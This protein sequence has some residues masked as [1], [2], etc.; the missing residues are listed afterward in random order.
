MS[1]EL[2]PS[3]GSGLTA[4]WE[5]VELTATGLTFSRDV[6]F[7]EWSAI[8]ERLQ[9]MGKAIQF[10]IGDW[11]RYGEHKFGEKYT[12]AV[13][14]TGYDEGSLRNMTWVAEQVDL[15]LRNDKLSFNHHAAVAPLKPAAQEA[16]LALAEDNNLSYRELRDEV[17]AF[18][19]AEQLQTA[20]PLPEGKYRVIYAD[21]PWRYA[22]SGLG[23]SAEQHYPT[24]STE[25]LRSLAV[26]ELAAEDAVLFLWATNPV[27]DE[28][29]SVMEAWGFEYK[30]NIVWTKDKATYGKLGFYVYGQH[31]LLLIGTRGS[32]LP[33]GEKPGSI[34]DAKKAEHSRKPTE[35]YEII[36]SMYPALEYVELFAR[37]VERAGWTVW[38]NESQP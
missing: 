11:V 28:A 37:K 21:P 34:L 9:F 7:D 26:S 32:M 5:A 17:R 6:S 4:Q 31:E 14:L 29:I 13:E 18:Q 3:G 16:L 8:G 15:S 35:A 24:M 1:M 22:N 23:G 30:T 33:T 38:G 12:Q 27:L 36:E 25:D 10:W 2:V 19:R 20:K